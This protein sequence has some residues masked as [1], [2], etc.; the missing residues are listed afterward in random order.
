MQHAA[1]QLG[2]PIGL[3]CTLL[4][5]IC[6]PS[7][8]ACATKTPE[9]PYSTAAHRAHVTESMDSAIVSASAGGSRGAGAT[10]ASNFQPGV[11][12]QRPTL[13]GVDRREIADGKKVLSKVRALR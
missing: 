10:T 5:T 8:L 9:G 3:G 2:L 7:L 4:K 12:L 6:S 1:Q 13:N 11:D